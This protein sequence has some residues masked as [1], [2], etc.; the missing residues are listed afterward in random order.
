MRV[1]VRVRVRVRV[2]ACGWGRVEWK[3]S[4]RPRASPCVGPLCHVVWSAFWVQY[5]PARADRVL[6]R[7]KPLFCR[8]VNVG[9]KGSTL[10]SLQ[11]AR[12]YPQI[13]ERMFAA[14]VVHPTPKWNNR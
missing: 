10:R 11:N 13:S 12:G 14:S 2:C 6:S 8:R 9:E 3:E 4:G 1:S 7:A 5:I